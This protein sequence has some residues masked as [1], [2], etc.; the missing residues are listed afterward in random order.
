MNKKIEVIT[1]M[2]KATDRDY[3]AR[4]ISNKIESMEVA[5]KYG[6]DYWDGERKYGYGGYRYIPGRW[7]NAAKLLI[8]RY[9]L[10]NKSKIIDIGCGKGY[11][12]YEIKKLL[13]EIFIRGTDISQYA[14]QHAHHDIKDYIS[15]H[16]AEKKL[17][18]ENHFFDLALS[19]GVLHN[20][21]IYDLESAL[22]EIERLGKNKYLMV[23][24]FRNEKELFNL[25]CWA[26]TAQAFFSEDEWKWIFHKFGYTGEYEF[27][28]F[29]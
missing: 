9:R 6:F 3:L 5:K 29:E 13:P 27:I 4:M 12:L 1:P 22:K 21:K 2:H 24:S 10:N 8:D 25:Q 15:I 16:S 17:Q 19:T 20:L 7:S 23:E 26:L 18:Y 11:L 14:L 28:F